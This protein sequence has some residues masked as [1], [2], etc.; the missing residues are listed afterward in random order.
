MAN[1]T[2]GFLQ[3]NLH[4]HTPT[5]KDRLYKAMVKPILEHKAIVWAPILRDMR[6]HNDKQLDLWPAITLVM[7][8]SHKCSQISIGL[9]L[10]DAE[11]NKKP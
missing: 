9:H 5:I 10:H 4:N 6:E 2:K 7:L 1:R 8:A 11:V 3:R